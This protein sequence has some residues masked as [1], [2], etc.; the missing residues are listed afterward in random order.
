V[1]AFADAAP[2]ALFAEHDS[3]GL[4]EWDRCACFRCADQLRQR[5]DEPLAR[6]GQIA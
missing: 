4:S 6:L 5:L 2:I 1:T 3:L